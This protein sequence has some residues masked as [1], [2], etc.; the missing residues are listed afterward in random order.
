V[1]K[2]EIAE[3]FRQLGA[4]LIGRRPEHP[5]PEVEFRIQ[6]SEEALH[7]AGRLKKERPEFNLAVLVETARLLDLKIGWV[8]QHDATRKAA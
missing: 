6:V 5:S 1:L 7:L 3:F 2:R 8:A 4:R